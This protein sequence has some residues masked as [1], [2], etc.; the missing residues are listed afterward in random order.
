MERKSPSTTSAAISAESVISGPFPLISESELTAEIFG[1]VLAREG[2]RAG[3]G[4][5]RCRNGIVSPA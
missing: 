3:P 2:V 5:W 1:V 4:A